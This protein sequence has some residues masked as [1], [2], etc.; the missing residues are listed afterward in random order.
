MSKNPHILLLLEASREYGRALL[1]GIAR[2]SSLYGPWTMERE[3]PFYLTRQEGG[4]KV[5]K[6]CKWLADGIIT[7]DSREIRALLSIP[8]PV[9]YASYL[10]ENT[11]NISRILTADEEIAKLG[12]MHFLQRG[13]RTF[14]YI[15][16]DNMYWSRNRG[17]YFC[18]EIQRHHYQVYCFQQSDKKADR[19]WAQEQFLLADWLSSLPKPCAVF[20]CN[21]DRAEQVLAAC[22]FVGLQV[23]ENIA[24]LGVDNDDI[25][26]SLANPPISSIALNIENAG[27]RAAQ[28]LDQ[29]MSGKQ[30]ESQTIIVEPRTVV[31]RQ[32]SDVSAIED[33]DVA[34]AVSYIRHHCNEPIQVSDVLRAVSISRRSIYDKFKRELQCSIYAFIKN[35]RIEQIGRLLSETD[36]PVSQI[37]LK[38]G[39]HSADHIAQYF[40]SQKG[41]NPLDYRKQFSVNTSN[42]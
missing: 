6:P 24:V 38:M 2:Y 13:F 20:C 25:I 36:I 1:R 4:N 18:Q 15:G 37:A 8:V 17:K 5:K 31:T 9:I 40:R 22:R 28:L 30:T 10:D 14:G 35:R 34:E 11:P 19:Q 39:F 27:F 12:A 33:K 7:R 23:P 16:Y 32:S 42:P 3:I 41:M 26:C 21:D 29:M